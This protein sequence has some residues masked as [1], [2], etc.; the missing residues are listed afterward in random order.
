MGFSDPQSPHVKPRTQPVP[1]SL[2]APPSGPRNLRSS[3]FAHP[4]SGSR[5]FPLKLQLARI[6]TVTT[7]ARP[8]FQRGPAARGRRSRPHRRA[9]SS[10]P[11]HRRNGSNIRFRPGGAP[12]SRPFAP[13]PSPEMAQPSGFRPG[14]DISRFGRGHELHCGIPMRV[15]TAATGGH[16]RPHAAA[17]LRQQTGAG[18][19]FAPLAPTFAPMTWL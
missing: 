7:G 1:S 3:R 5:F 17:A 8:A 4:A 19:I 2:P 6:S 12:S 16:P 11:A 10:R 15:S 14:P 13:G 9:P 18:A